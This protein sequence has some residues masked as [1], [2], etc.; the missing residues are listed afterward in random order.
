MFLLLSKG[1][2]PIPFPAAFL[3][4]LLRVGV[5]VAR[6]GKIARKMLLIG[7]GTGG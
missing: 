6:F 7:G 5:D 2:L 4:H 1:C 3:L